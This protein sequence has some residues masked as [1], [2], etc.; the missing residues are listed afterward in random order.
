MLTVAQIQKDL[1]LK[2]IK[3]V[4][5]KVFMAY[6][7]EGTLDTL[8]VKAFD[9][10]VDLGA[11]RIPN[12]APYIC[13]MMGNDPSPFV[14]RNIQ[15]AFGRGLGMIAVGDQ[16]RNQP[17]G[18]DNMIIEDSSTDYQGASSRKADLAKETV[19]GAVAALK[20]ELQ[21]DAVIKK[22]LWRAIMLDSLHLLGRPVC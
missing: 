18:Y 20:R 10:M 12:L 1:M 22:G 16:R 4:D 7:R 11:L 8:R 21:N 5:N 17:N 3:D 2:G 6:T 14:R 9:C 13:Y 19:V 15:V